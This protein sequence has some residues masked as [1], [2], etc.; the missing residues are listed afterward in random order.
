MI[1]GNTSP[2]IMWGPRNRWIAK[3]FDA[4]DRLAQMP[5]IGHRREDLTPYAVRFWL[6]GA[7]VVIYR[8]ERSPI[9]IVAVAQGSRDIPLFLERRMHIQA[10]NPETKSP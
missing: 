3:L 8:A 7:Y 10:S 5:D 6:V 9:E 2:K 4:F 1:F